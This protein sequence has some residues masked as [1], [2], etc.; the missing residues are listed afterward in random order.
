MEEPKKEDFGKMELW[1]EKL[2][3]IS[4]LVK[5]SRFELPVRPPHPLGGVAK[6]RSLFVAT[7]PLLLSRRSSA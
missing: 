3:Q 6:S 1:V 5:V 2:R 4:R 7:P